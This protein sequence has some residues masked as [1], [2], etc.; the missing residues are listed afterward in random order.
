MIPA[1]SVDQSAAA[2]IAALR[3]IYKAFP[4]VIANDNIDLDLRP[5]EIH[6]LLGENGAG[7]STL[8]SILAGIYRP[9]KGQVSVDGAPVQFHSPA[10]SIAAGIGM[11]HQHFRLVPALTVAE[12]IHMGW[13]R[14]PRRASIKL[15]STRTS[16][17]A[18]QFGLTIKPDARV[19]ELSPGEQQRVEILRVL[20]RGARVL[21]LDEPTAVLTPTEVRLLFKSLHALTA[22]GT[23]I[24]FISHKLDEVMEIAN[25]ITILRGGRK[26]ASGPT[27]EF[28]TSSLAKLMVGREI[29]ATQYPRPVHIG[30][31]VMQ[32]S[33]V[34]ALDDRGAAALRN[35]SLVL[36]AGEILGIAGV[37]GNGQKE[38]AQAMT[39][40]RPVTA[41]RVEIGGKD[42]TNA[43]PVRFLKAGVA[44]I[45]EDRLRTAVAARLTVADNIVLREYR[46]QPV[47]YGAWFNRGA[48]AV[49]AR[50]IAD[51]ANVTVSRLDMPFGNLSGGNQQRLV[52]RRERRISRTV[53]IA[54]YPTRGL[55]IGAV[56]TLRRML[57]DLRDAGV[58]VLL[59][60][61]ELDEL[62]ALAD[63]IAVMFRGTIAGVFARDDAKLEDIGLLMGGAR[64]TKR[65]AA[66]IVV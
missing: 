14:T 34:D 15:L 55:D 16:A 46:S 6:A 60:S 59:I 51:E 40:L 20:A 41:G 65:P 53:L 52:A 49:L 58:S 4:P 45:P 39:G 57:I 3:G 56:D 12:N 61:E 9:D 50:T 38:L 35:V 17:L 63:R 29:A 21:V 22:K 18:E 7:K 10:D 19:E 66:T 26:V 36:R 28:N 33:A 13:L 48:A 25:H 31:E 32:L 62:F 1:F 42:F 11:V 44:H 24:A 30:R 47:S 5:N 43:E 23:A 27:T 8:M 2:P 37:A 64:D 54:A